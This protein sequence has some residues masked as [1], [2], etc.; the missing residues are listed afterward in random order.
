[1]DSGLVRR[2]VAFLEAR[3]RGAVTS[4]A[5]VLALLVG[6]FDYL[7]GPELASLLFYLIPVAIAGIG[8]RKVDALAIAVVAGAC[9]FAAEALRGRE[10]EV[11]WILFWNALSRVAVFA[12]IG[13]L[14]SLLRS[15]PETPAGGPR[16]SYCGSRNTI[17][18]RRNLVCLACR[19][20]FT[21]EQAE[22]GTS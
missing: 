1:V 4:A 21:L 11:E 19:R 18:L 12:L 14:V 8:A 16:C 2:I 9:W 6:L 5:L 20:I 15:A 10:Y 17:E 3:P 22:G 13:T 7:T